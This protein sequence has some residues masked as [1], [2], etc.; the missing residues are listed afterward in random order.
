MNMKEIAELAGV[1]VAAVSYALNGTGNIS[2]KKRKEILEIVK[3]EGYSPNRIAKSLRT[4]K[5]STIGIMVEDIT[6]FQTPRIL[7]GINEYAEKNGRSEERRVGK[8]C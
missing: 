4:K 6:S 5:S 1:S 8:E 7:N 2:E 3:K